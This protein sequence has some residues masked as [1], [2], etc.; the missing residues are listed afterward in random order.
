[1]R[2]RLTLACVLL[3][4]VVRCGSIETTAAVGPRAGLPRVRAQVSGGTVRFEKKTVRRTIEQAAQN[5][6]AYQQ[7]PLYARVPA[8]VKKVH[9]DVGD[10]V[11]QGQVL[12][13]LSVPELD[14]ELKQ[15]QADVSAALAL[16]RQAEKAL[17][18]AEA[19]MRSAKAGVG[20]AQAGRRRAQAEVSRSKSQHERLSRAGKSGVIDRESVA[21]TRYTYEAAEAQAGEV[22][23]RV[24]SAQ[25][26]RD[27]SESKRDRAAADVDVAKARHL[28]AQAA[29]DQ[30][31]AFAG[32]AQIKAPFDGVVTQRGANE[33]HLVQPA[34]GAARGTP[35]LT[36]D[37]VD[38]MRVFVHLPEQEARWIDARTAEEGPKAK[39][40]GQSLGGRILDGRVT[41]SAF[42][43]DPKSRTLRTE[44]DLPNPD[45]ALRP[46]SFV[47]VTIDVERVGVW[48]LPTSAV[49]QRDGE[50]WC[51]V[52]DGGKARKLRLL[53]GLEGGGLVEVRKAE[54]KGG[55]TEP[56]G[57]ESVIANP[58]AALKDGD[59]VK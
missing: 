48:T 5:V 27:E 33:G 35:L 21:E 53:V 11:K 45:R 28:V 55:W 34:A 37:Q 8:Y 4:A 2:L 18:A 16:T 49:K 1:M 56:T 51:F 40:R 57:S 59:A 44:I 54:T 39:V 30:T 12:I 3:L 29:R 38:V 26:L 23:A 52:N 20:E 13:E 42:G 25:A 58:S 41:R 36:V 24:T 7:A 22:E 47:V 9:V 46:G 15:K 31:G 43:L 19:N 6:D 32:F 50:V 17:S 10:R 14:A